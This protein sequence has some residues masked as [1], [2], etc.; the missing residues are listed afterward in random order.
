MAHGVERAP[1]P[2][3]LPGLHEVDRCVSG[4]CA[5]RT[6]ARSPR[7]SVTMSQIVFLHFYL[8]RRLRGRSPELARVHR[9]LSPWA[10]GPAAGSPACST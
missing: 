9:Q 2:L 4:E 3:R 7:A 5:A 6:L 8:A 10:A 1:S